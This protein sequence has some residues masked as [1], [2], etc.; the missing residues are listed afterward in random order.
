MRNSSLHLVNLR[1]HY[2]GNHSIEGATL[3][4]IA[5]VLNLKDLH[6]PVL[7][8][9]REDADRIVVARGTVNEG[10][11]ACDLRRDILIFWS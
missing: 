6:F 4:G 8:D 10:V 7:L 2:F 1:S 5:E 3:L 11:H 9:E